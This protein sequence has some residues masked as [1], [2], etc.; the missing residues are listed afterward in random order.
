[1][2]FLLII[3]YNACLIGV[4][5]VCY[6]GLMRVVFLMTCSYPDAAESDVR[7]YERSFKKL[8]PAHKV[9]SVIFSV[10]VLSFSWNFG[11]GN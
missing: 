2:R 3:R 6:I 4:C 11:R 8:P 10:S 5:H 9:F 7:R 1:M